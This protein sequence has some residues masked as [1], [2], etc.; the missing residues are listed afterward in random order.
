MTTEIA[1]VK[2]RG[3]P[4][5]RGQSGNPNGRPKGARNRATLASESLLDGEADALTRKAIELALAGDTMAL[6]LCL[7][8]VLPPRKDRPISLA[9]PPITSPEDAAMASNAVL[10]AVAAGHITLSEGS[11][12]LDLIRACRH[13]AMP[14]APEAPVNHVVQIKFVGCQELGMGREVEG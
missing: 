8:R 2:Q 7:E 14:E 6:R 5:K 13:A 11:G 4:F 3:R 1:A 10:T 9:V 12:V